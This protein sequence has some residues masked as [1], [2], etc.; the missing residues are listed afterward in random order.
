MIIRI[1]NNAE[2]VAINCAM[3]IASQV[4]NKP[5]SILGLATGSSPIL[6]YEYLIKWHQEGLVDFSSATSF[7][8][9]EYLGLEPSHEQSYHYFMQDKLFSKINLKQSFLPNG[10][11]ENL[12]EECVNYENKIASMGGIDLQL[13]GLGT[14]AH[15]G[16]NE[17]DSVFSKS[18]RVVDLAE[19]TIDAN[20]RFFESADDVPKKAITMGIGT[21]LR[22]KKILLIAYGKSKAEAIRNM[23]KGD[24]DPMVPSSILNVHK[25]VTI[26]IDKEAA[27]LL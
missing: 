25:N 22:S 10:N 23:V 26:L 2:Q 4:I 24:I 1:L 16:F 18:T 13:L 19:S 9:D 6:S 11:A 7:N 27:S 5:D 20:K 12:D 21:I 3:L 15:I 17:P 14:N 8:L